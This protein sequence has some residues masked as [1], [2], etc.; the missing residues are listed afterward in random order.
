MAVPAVTF[1]ELRA[2]AL[3]KLPAELTTLAVPPVRLA[4]D[5]DPTVRLPNVALAVK[6]TQEAAA[7][8]E[9]AVPA[10]PSS[11]RSATSPYS[12]TDDSS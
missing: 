7:V 1:N 12:S 6:V 11:L 10:V 2:A 4:V 5:D 3:S 9:A 8:A